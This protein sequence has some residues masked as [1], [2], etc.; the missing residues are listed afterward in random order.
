MNE[1]ELID[2]WSPEE[3]QSEACVTTASSSLKPAAVITGPSRD[4]MYF[5]NIFLSSN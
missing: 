4:I 1:I 5:C 2:T 3:R